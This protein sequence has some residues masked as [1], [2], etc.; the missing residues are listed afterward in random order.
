MLTRDAERRA[1][2]RGRV[3]HERPQPRVRAHDVVASQVDGERP[4]RRTEDLV[5]IVAGRDHRVGAAV[6][7]HV[8]RPDEPVPGPRNEEH[9]LAGHADRETES[10]WDPVAPNDQVCASAWA[11]DGRLRLAAVR[12][13]IGRAVSRERAVRLA[14]PDT[15]RVDHRSRSDLDRRAGELVA[16]MRTRDPSSL[17][18]RAGDAGPREDEGAVLLGRPRDRKGEPGVVLD[19]VVE[20][21]CA[22]KTVPPERGRR[23]ERV[24]HA[25]EAV[26]A[27]VPSRA[28]EVV[29]REAAPVERPREHGAVQ[30]EQQRLEADEMR[31]EPK[32]AAPLG[33]RFA[34]EPEPELLEVA[35]PAVDEPRRP[36]RRP[37]GDVRSLH[38]GDVEPPTCRVESC[39]RTGDTTA[40]DEDIPGLVGQAAKLGGAMLRRGRAS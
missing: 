22:A 2:P 3:G 39:P 9:D 28:E 20:H 24:G 5:D 23:L 6:E 1:V 34:D 12:A 15:C 25:E 21:E 18:D 4:I 14:G 36:A 7:G 32:K 13:A 35:E 29:Q 19:P 38:Q 33:E 11:H 26:P 8:R 31:S 10:R 16:R 30:R 37:R 27:A 17:P 40:D